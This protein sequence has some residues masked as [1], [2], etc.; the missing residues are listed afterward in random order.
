MGGI[1]HQP[2]NRTGTRY[3]VI[4]TRLSRAFTEARSFFERANV[5]LEDVIISELEDQKP[6]PAAYESC[7]AQLDTAILQ[8]PYALTLLDQLEREMKEKGYKPL[9]SFALYANPNSATELGNELAKAGLLDATV[10]SSIVP[11]QLH[12]DGF[13]AAIPVL[14]HAI[15]SLISSMTALKDDMHSARHLAAEGLIANELETNGSLNFRSAFM[16]AYARWNYAYSLFLTSAT[17]STEMWYQSMG[18]G[19]LV[20]GLQRHKMVG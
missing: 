5:Q 1:N 16:V 18:Y 8:L 6:N 7:L 2:C 9:P 20:L 15:Q 14:R 19:S 3:L 12:G 4:S 13:Y 10:F 11:P 17:W